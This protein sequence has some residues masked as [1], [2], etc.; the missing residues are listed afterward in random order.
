MFEASR[1]Q[2]ERK[3]QLLSREGYL[4][5][6]KVSIFLQEML[7]G[8]MVEYWHHKMRMRNIA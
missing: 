7:A 2:P 3:R 6:K 4:L 1:I 8:I 5:S